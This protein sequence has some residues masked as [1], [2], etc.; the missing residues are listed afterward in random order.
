MESPDGSPSD[1]DI[2]TE[3]F[4]RP[5]EEGQMVIHL[6]VYDYLM[7]DNKMKAVALLN[8]GQS[9]TRFMHMHK[10]ILEPG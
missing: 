9:L 8:S 10:E 3:E 4:K 5:K 7:E 1:A 6:T 2:Y